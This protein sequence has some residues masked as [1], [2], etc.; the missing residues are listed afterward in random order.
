MARVEQGF[1]GQQVAALPVDVMERM[2]LEGRAGTFLACMAG[3]FP[4]AY[5]HYCE[6]DSGI[7][8][9]AMLLYCIKG[10]GKV[11]F[12]GNEYTVGED[13]FFYVDKDT[14]HRFMADER[15]PWTIYWLHFDMTAAEPLKPFLQAPAVGA[16]NSRGRMEFISLFER[17]IR[18]L[19]GGSEE[20]NLLQANITAGYL[21]SGFCFRS[22]GE[23]KNE[24]VSQDSL[25]DLCEH[26]MRASIHKN[27][28]L[29]E[30]SSRYGYSVSYLQRVFRDKKGV[31]PKQYFL[32]MKMDKAKE[33]LARSDMNITELSNRIGYD[34]PLHFSKLFKKHTGY[35]PTEYRKRSRSTQNTNNL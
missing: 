23:E 35:N 11:E 9:T 33:L 20:E 26:Y 17:V 30:L 29:E 1:R 16:V 4:H 12:G 15:E 19:G 3:Y 21:M 5:G 24:R 6:R 10:K 27:L 18:L 28:S 7:S 2:R 25:V 13:M 32:R 22:F 31:P 34:D 14:P 8:G